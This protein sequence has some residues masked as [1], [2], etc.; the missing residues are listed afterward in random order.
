MMHPKQAEMHSIS[1]DIFRL[2]NRLLH[3]QE[4]YRVKKKH[5]E[6]KK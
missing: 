6:K 1:N 4:T 5:E 3:S 2:I